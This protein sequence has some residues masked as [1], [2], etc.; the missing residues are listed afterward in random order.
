VLVDILVN[1]HWESP[2]RCYVRP[3][4][5]AARLACLAAAAFIGSTV[6]YALTGRKS[7][8]PAVGAVAVEFDKPT[9]MVRM[10]YEVLYEKKPFPDAVLLYYDNGVLRDPVGG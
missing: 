5:N 8:P 9:K 1:G 3:M 10:K 2:E 7:L 6:T 4:R